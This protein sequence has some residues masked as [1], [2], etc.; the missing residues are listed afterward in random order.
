V[1]TVDAASDD[2][3]RATTHHGVALLTWPSNE[4]TRRTLAARRVP[5]LLVVPANSPP[6]VVIDTLEDWVREP[7]DAADVDARAV[8]LARRAEMLAPEAAVVVP[9]ASD[10]WLVDP[11]DVERFVESTRTTARREPEAP[12]MDTVNGI[13]RV[14]DRWVV[15]PERQVPV[16]ALLVERFGELVGRDEVVAAYVEAGGSADTTAVKSMTL[17]LGRRLAP[18]GLELRAVRSHGLVLGPAPVA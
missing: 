6:P 1:T 17:R 11:A 9:T 14:A 3:T 10:G 7:I 18:L 15:V 8:A 16:A 2:A 5:R 12:T 4:P 13:V